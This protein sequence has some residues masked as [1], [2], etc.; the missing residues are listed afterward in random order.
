[1]KN[2]RDIDFNKLDCYELENVL[3]FW[4]YFIYYILKYKYSNFL[5]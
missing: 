5:I 2:K 3:Y 1:M 4:Y